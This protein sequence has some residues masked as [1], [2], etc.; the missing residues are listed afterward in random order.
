MCKCPFIILPA[1][2]AVVLIDSS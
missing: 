2:V 1:S